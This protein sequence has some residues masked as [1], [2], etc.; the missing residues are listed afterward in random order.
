MNENI[1]FAFETK[2]GTVFRLNV[3]ATTIFQAANEILE[4]IALGDL[5]VDPREIVKIVDI[6]G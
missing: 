5:N 2:D 4:S 3:K 6:P 1:Q